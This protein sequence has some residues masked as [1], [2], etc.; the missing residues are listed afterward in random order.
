LADVVA[1][2]AVLRVEEAAD[3]LQFGLAA[4]DIDRCH[5]RHGTSGAERRTRKRADIGWTS[6]RRLSD[7]W[8]ASDII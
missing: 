3:P 8:Q 5:R 7:A 2:L 6:P 1:G 4:D